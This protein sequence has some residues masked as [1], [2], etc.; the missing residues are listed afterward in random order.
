MAKS[1][2]LRARHWVMVSKENGGQDGAMKDSMVNTD[3]GVPPWDSCFVLRRQTPCGG[4]EKVTIES[5]FYESG[6]SHSR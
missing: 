1:L 6:L 3:G 5:A 2:L 4:Y